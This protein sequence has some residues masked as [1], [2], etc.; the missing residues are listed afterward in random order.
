MTCPKCGS[1]L[2]EENMYCEVCGE[3]IH[4][5]PE[6]VPEVESSIESSLQELVMEF[7]N[8]NVGAVRKKILKALYIAV[9]ATLLSIL[10]LSVGI[11]IYHDN[12]AA[13]QIKEGNE[14]YKSGHY[15]QAIG[16][17]KNAVAIEPENIEYRLKLGDTYLIMENV[18]AAIE[19]FKDMIIY[20]PENTLAYA[21]IIALYEKYNQYS[22]IND[23][24]QGYAS[25]SIKSEFVDYLAL[26]P[27]F[28]DA[29]GEY[30][31][32]IN[33][34]LTNESS[35]KIYYTLDGSIPDENSEVYASPIELKRG[36]HV[37]NAVFQNEYGVLSENIVNEYVIMASAPDE[38]I[39]SLASGS[40]ETPQLIKIIPPDGCSVYYTLDGSVP[41][42]NGRIYGE[43]IPLESG[44]S[45][46]KFAAIDN[47]NISSE[48]VEREY[49]LVVEAAFSEEQ[50][51]EL[52]MQHL[53]D[54]QYIKDISG[55]SENYPGTFSYLFAELRNISGVSMYC[56]NEY[57]VYG[58]SAKA[59]TSNKFGVNV[60][61]GDIYLVKHGTN[62]SYVASLF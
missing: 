44:L 43:P 4:I 14:N 22:A 20:D 32:S 30:E 45:R 49:S 3:E 1:S 5:V 56:Y 61:T 35:G 54:K 58:R 24:L 18:E 25:E 47:K 60:L 33:L 51:L 19:A 21:Q 27:T 36:N 50:G 23:F 41:D 17:Y 39:I 8:G 2:G 38:P 40:Y 53:V 34:T 6:F 48:V 42:R 26:P 15:K 46:Y 12:S 62:D 29:G 57:Y 31:A 7:K 13:Y 37:V 59:M 52:L 9:P 10:L 28:S 55:A 16:Y 11:M